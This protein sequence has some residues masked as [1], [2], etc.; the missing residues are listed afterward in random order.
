MKRA[1]IYIGIMVGAALILSAVS[2]L[3]YK[4]TMEKYEEKLVTQTQETKPITKVETNKE[5]ATKE[6]DTVK[7]DRIT[8]ST[9]FKLI[10]YDLQNNSYKEETKK[11]PSD[12]I[13]LNREELLDSLSE[14]MKELPLEEVRAGLLSY[15]LQSFSNKTIALIKNY[16]STS[17]PY[18][19][20]VTVVNYEVVV[21]YCDKKT[22]F[23]YTGIDARNL[24]YE[25]QNK[26][27]EG[28]YVLDKEELYG[29]LE[30]YSS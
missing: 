27:I 30:N 26:L 19:Y 24:S 11:I 21:Y 25:D 13:G 6:A 9:V 17:M 29:I 8:S 16:D 15:D 2:Y 3:S 28:I 5:P 23:E 1:Y 7:Q 18:E 20:Y 14:Y 4:K 10:T 12:W 22:I